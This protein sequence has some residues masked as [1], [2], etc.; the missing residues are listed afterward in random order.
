MRQQPLVSPARGDQRHDLVT[1]D[2]LALFVDDMDAVGVA[3]ERDTEVS[4]IVE[5]R[6]LA[7]G[8]VGRAAFL[9]NV[10]AIR[11]DAEAD[12][13][14]PQFPHHLGRGGIG[15]AVGAV[16]DDL[17]PAEC[18]ATR[19]C[20]LAELDVAAPPVVQPFGPADMTGRRQLRRFLHQRF[21]LRLDLVGQLEAVRAEQF[22]AVILE[23]IVRCRNHHADIGT[24]RAG[25]HANR[26]GRHWPELDHIHA[27]AGETG[28]Q[29]GLKHIAGSAGVL[30]DHH[31]VAVRT[32]SEIMPRRH[33]QAHGDL[34]SHRPGICQAADTVGAKILAAHVLTF[35]ARL[36][37][38]YLP[39]QLHAILAVP[40]AFPRHHAPAKNGRPAPDQ[41]VQPRPNPTPDHLL[42]PP[43]SAC[44]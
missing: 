32:S 34:R 2:D 11:R 16:D 15:G 14:G 9:V 25:Q 1:V 23:R 37:R 5:D 42:R 33:A 41:I 27:N 28:G 12:H 17:Q 6:L 44:Q 21:D 20:R 13:V 26:R 39:W 38:F 35:P 36:K 19:K 29:R 40:G 24:N 8:G 7:S 3:I 18:P 30:A 4:T 22:D 43:R 10:L 31:G